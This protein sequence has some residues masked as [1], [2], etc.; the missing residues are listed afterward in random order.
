M[1]E[2]GRFFPPWTG[3]QAAW[4]HTRLRY[5]GNHSASPEAERG[6]RRRAGV[7][8][9]WRVMVWGG[10]GQLWQR[11]YRRKEVTAPESE[12]DGMPFTSRCSWFLRGPCRG[13]R[14]I[15]GIKTRAR[16][17]WGSRW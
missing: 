2:M 8:G 16:R 14:H 3:R 10:G 17:G 7:W 4:R 6:R 11:L 15:L 13:E 12:E 1:T 9:V 5:T